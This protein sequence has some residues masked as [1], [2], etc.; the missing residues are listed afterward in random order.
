MDGDPPSQPFLNAAFQD[1]DTPTHIQNVRSQQQEI[2][3]APFNCVAR[4][5]V[6]GRSPA[7]PK[8]TREPSP[9][10]AENGVKLETSNQWRRSSN[11]L[12]RRK[13][14]VT[15]RGSSMPVHHNT[16]PDPSTHHHRQR[17][18]AKSAP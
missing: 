12:R 15:G 11:W 17:E 5:E 10:K 6:K 16:V 13:T 2:S 3:K 1:Y 9:S 18:T 7:P 8:D 4:A 14:R